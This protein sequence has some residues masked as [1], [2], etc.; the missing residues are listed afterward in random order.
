MA[1]R[2]LGC[3]VADVDASG[4]N[5]DAKRTPV[6]AMAKLLRPLLVREWNDEI[7]RVADAFEPDILIAF[8][9]FMVSRHTLDKR[10]GA[11]SDSTTTIRTGWCSSWG[12]IWKRRCLN[13]IVCSIPSERWMGTRPNEFHWRASTFLPHGYD[14]EVH[15]P[16]QLDADDR[17]RYGCDVSFVGTWSPLKEEMHALVSLRPNLDLHV[18]GN[19]WERSRSSVLRR[20]IRGPALIGTAYARAIAAARINLGLLGVTREV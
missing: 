19:I 4:T 2:R 16:M 20:V 10:E 3:D 7:L 18:R 15:V 14:P 1:L 12:H 13:T 8:K 11:A 9:G 5:M 6:R 17:K